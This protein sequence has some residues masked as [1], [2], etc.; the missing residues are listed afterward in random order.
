MSELWT[1]CDPDLPDIDGAPRPSYAL[2]GG[3]RHAKPESNHKKRKRHDEDG[4]HLYCGH[5]SYVEF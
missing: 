4:C 5:S 2:N 3:F 1:L